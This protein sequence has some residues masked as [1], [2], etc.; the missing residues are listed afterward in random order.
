MSGGADFDLAVVGS[1]FGGSLLAMVARRIGLRVVL[2]E[3]GSHP[4]F[5]IGEST[6]PLANLLLEQLAARYDL[7]SLAPLATYGSWLREYPEVRRGLKRGFTFFHHREGR[8]FGAAADR[9]DQLMVAASPNDRVADTH[10]L[11][12]DVDHLLVGEAA[13]I[14]V[15]YLD[16]TL[17]ESVEIPGGGRTARLAGTRRRRPA[18]LRARLVVD[19]SGPRGLLGRALGIPQAPLP[20]MPRT[21][22][23]F[24]H[25][26]GVARCD[27]MEAFRTAGTPPY[28]IDDAA[29]HHVFDG[30]WMWVLRFDHGVTS[31][32]FMLEERLAR[33]VDLEDGHAAWRQLL[34]RFPSIAEQFAAAEPV[35]PFRASRDVTYRAS[36]AAGDGWALL[37]S[38]AGF[39]DPL[40]S[41]G[42]PLTLLGV[43]RLGRLLETGVTRD[44]LAEYAETTLFELDR[45]AAFVA[46][47]Y[48][49][50]ADFPGFAITS[51]IYFA[52]ASFAETARRLDRAHLAPRFLAADRPE[53]HAAVRSGAEAIARAVEPINVAGLCDPAKANWYG[54]DVADAVAAA[55]KLGATGD[56]VR[57]ALRGFVAG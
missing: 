56:E 7:P 26:T 37:P 38:A 6:S 15:E 31:A 23:L 55:H 44:G 52:A 24:A 17:L 8:P 12:A 54:V 9:S 5:A 10:W 19:A 33:D 13:R 51:M 43:E 11:R 4:R 1:G 27:E 36:A 48:A 53:I 21:A 30:G 2:V 14:G 32:G 42:I 29:L 16:E 41:T 3:R 49:A 22:T 20:A 45:T 47:S 46:A 28:P 57:R 34:S 50:F 25:F 18:E 40:F 39:V 35:L